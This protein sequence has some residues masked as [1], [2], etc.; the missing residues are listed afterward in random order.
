MGVGKAGIL[1]HFS[2]LFARG[3]A[4]GNKKLADVGPWLRDQI[5]SYAKR[6]GEPRSFAPVVS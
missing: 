4:G 1:C 3:D 6:C 5:L 2:T